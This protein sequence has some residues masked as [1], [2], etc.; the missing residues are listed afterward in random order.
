MLSN[1]IRE[2]Q[3]DIED[4]FTSTQDFENWEW[5][6]DESEIEIEH[7]NML[8]HLRFSLS[9]FMKVKVVVT[10]FECVPVRGEKRY[11]PAK[12]NEL[13]REALNKVFIYLLC[14]RYLDLEEEEVDA[15]RQ[16]EKDDQDRKEMQ[17]TYSS[18][19]SQF[20]NVGL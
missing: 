8:Y 11:F 12:P 15:K 14:E 9:G 1:I 17:E 10:F 2:L 7:N 18:L 13:L 6:R 20:Y 16:E 3:S 19:Q 5:G 4:M